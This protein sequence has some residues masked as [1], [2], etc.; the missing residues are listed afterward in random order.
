MVCTQNDFV[1]GG[2][3]MNKTKRI[4]AIVFIS[5]LL[6]SIALYFRLGKNH[7][8]QAVLPEKESITSVQI[9]SEKEK[10]SIEIAKEKIDSSR[11]MKVLSLSSSNMESFDTAD[12]E[13]NIRYTAKFDDGS[14]VDFDK[15]I[16]LISY[17]N[18]DRKTKNSQISNED[19]INVLKQEY[20]I[21][22]TYQMDTVYEA[23]E[24][25]KDDTK[26]YWSKT[27]ENG[28]QNFYDALSVRIDGSNNEI[29]TFNRFNDVSKPS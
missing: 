25:G 14:A 28:V 15:D 3:N 10:S 26:Y 21:D 23:N 22:E 7:K 16:N 13:S 1:L 8:T 4:I 2:K 17:S 12:Y 19:L 24:N 29:L 18:F 20:N 6:L 11:V 5:L 27:E 9:S